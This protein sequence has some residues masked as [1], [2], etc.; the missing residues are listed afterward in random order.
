[1]ETSLRDPKSLKPNPWNTN[2]VPPDNM[3]KLKRSIS[4]LGFASAVVVRE[5]PNGDLQILGGH[6]RVEAAVEMG[7]REVPVLNLGRMEDAKAK[8]IGLVDNS[9]YGTD[10][11]IS[12]AQLYTELGLTNED[13]AAFLPYSELDFDTV[14]KA[15]DI[16]L[17]DLDITLD[18]DEPGDPEAI[19]E[20]PAKTH[21]ILKF[22]VSLGNAE[23]I[24]QAVEKTIK[25]Q[26]FDSETDDLTAAGEALAYLL[27]NADDAE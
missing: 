22:R 18:D 4:D 1:M 8:K 24:R 10:D 19:R 27:L 17:D 9:R 20:R 12:L 3:V 23:R 14:K 16:D 6:H 11:T 26:G 25:R 21:D 2:R 15:I 13:L 7:I 5:L